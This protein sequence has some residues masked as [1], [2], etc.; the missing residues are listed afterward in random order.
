M[1]KVLIVANTVS[2]IKLFNQSNIAILRSLGYEIHVACN[3]REGN[4]ISAEAVGQA[5]QEWEAQGF[6]V[7]HIDVP[8]NPVPRKMAAAFR[9]LKK[10]IGQEDLRLIHCHTPVAAALT[11][12][13][14]AKARSQGRVKVIYTAHGFHFFKGASLKNWLLYYPVEKLCACYTDALITINREDHRMAEKKFSAGRNY[15]LPGVGVDT[16]A[17]A[18]GAVTPEARDALRAE[19]GIGKDCGM[20]LSVGELIPRKNYRAAIDAVARLKHGNFRYVICG[21]G[22]LLEELRAYAKARG[23]ADAVVFL[24]FRRDIAKLCACADVFLHTSYQEGLPV[25][26]MEAMASGL[27]VVASRIRGNV[28]LIEDGVNGLLCEPEDAVGFAHGLRTLLEEPELARKFRKHSLEK[29][30]SYD[31]SI[32][33]QQL[34][35]IY[36]EINDGVNTAAEEV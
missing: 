9:Q 28:D 14:A 13:A 34:R 25:A 10:L 7:H 26:V 23:V 15:C 2:M 31:Q 5:V 12:I 1:K 6:R 36:C 32:V 35:Q 11:R 24:G 33:A 17:F 29:I 4:T 19:L 22:A 8:R 21:Q 16:A 3:F 27:P 20:I 30:K 18:P